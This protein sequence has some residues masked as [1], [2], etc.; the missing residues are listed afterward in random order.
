MLE[1]GGRRR[2]IEEKV[3]EKDSTMGTDRGIVAE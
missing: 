1:E 3:R 2:E